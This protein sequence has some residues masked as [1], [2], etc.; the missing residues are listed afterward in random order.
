RARRGDVA[1]D[2]VAHELDVLGS[3]E[4]LEVHHAEVR[5]PL[6][7]AVH[8]EHVRDTTRHARGEVPAGAPEHDDAPARHVLAAVVADAFHDRVD[9]AVPHAEPFTGEDRKSTRLNSSH[10]W[11]SYA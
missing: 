7:V 9:A 8:V 5:A 6:E 10:E 11:I 2:Q 1:S 4:R 3:V